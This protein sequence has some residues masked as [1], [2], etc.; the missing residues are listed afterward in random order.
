MSRDP[1][2]VGTDGSPRAMRAVD[3][4]GQLAQALDAPVHVVCATAAIGAADWPPRITG[5]QIVA[6]AVET[7]NARGVTAETHLPTGDASL[8]LVALADSERAQLLVVGNRGMTGIRRFLG[9]L[10]NRVSH[11]AQCDVL[12]V[13]T[14]SESPALAGGAVV[15]GTAGSEGSE[16]VVKE[17][18]RMAS[19]L[20]AELHIL[21]T[22]TPSESV[23]AAAA[24]QAADGGVNAITHGRDGNPADALLD[25][26]KKQEAGII[27]VGSKGMQS[28]D[29]DRLGN[30]PDKLSHSGGASILIVFSTG[31]QT[32]DAMS[33]AASGEEASA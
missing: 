10:P 31:A 19:A 15:V 27:V 23:L 6:E 30:V 18:T 14:E 32:G 29:R 4:A 25:V 8:E 24:A 11:Q 17:G 16:R 2:V 28:G 12:I 26:A 21:T 7:L 22:A 5:Q 33:A 9:S 1:I 20:G 13:D 3:T